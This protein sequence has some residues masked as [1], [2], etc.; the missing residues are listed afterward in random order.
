MHPPQKNEIIYS[1][2]KEFFKI[3]VINADNTRLDYKLHLIQKPFFTWS[4]SQTKLNEGFCYGGLK[5]LGILS[6]GRVVPCCFDTQGNITL[7]D[8]KHQNLKEIL[9]TQ[10]FLKLIEGFRQEKRI[11]DYCKACAYPNYLKQFDS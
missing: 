1:K 11:E 6:D 9:Q 2:L 4:P 8:L 3:D 5:Q 7:G 10:R